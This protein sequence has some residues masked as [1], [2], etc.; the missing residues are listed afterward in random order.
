[1]RDVCLERLTFALAANLCYVVCSVSLVQQSL[2]GVQLVYGLVGEGITFLP[3]KPFN[4]LTL[5]RLTHLLWP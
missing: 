1:M 5:Y 2:I 3:D 4:D